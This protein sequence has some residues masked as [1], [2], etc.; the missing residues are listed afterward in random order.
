MNA[1]ITFREY[2]QRKFNNLLNTVQYAKNSGTRSTHAARPL[3]VRASCRSL[4]KREHDISKILS[5]TV[6]PESVKLTLQLCVYLQGL[7][8][9]S[10]ICET[11]GMS[12]LRKWRSSF[13][14]THPVLMYPSNLLYAFTMSTPVS[15]VTWREKEEVDYASCLDTKHC[16]SSRM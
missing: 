6:W 13:V 10:T 9:T 14:G 5:E 1:E 12:S 15:W 8:K 2:C 7:T 11:A 3:T 4:R 16:F